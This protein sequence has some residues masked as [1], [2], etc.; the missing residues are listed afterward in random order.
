MIKIDESWKLLALMEAFVRFGAERLVEIRVCWLHCDWIRIEMN[1]LILITIPAFVR[2]LMEN[3]LLDENFV[4]FSNI[5]KKFLCFSKLWVL[6]VSAL[7]CFLF[8][9][10]D[11]RRPFTYPR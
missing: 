6:I 10:C 1:F 11:V 7:Q 5:F 8:C 9:C 2:Y 4:N 3:L